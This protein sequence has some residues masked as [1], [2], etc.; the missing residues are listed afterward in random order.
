ME[1]CCIKIITNVSSVLGVISAVV[2]IATWIIPSKFSIELKVIIFLISLIVIFICIAINF[3]CNNCVLKNQL[4]ELR[5]NHK[6]ICKSYDK[7]RKLSEQYKTAFEI[8][9]LSLT[10][11]DGKTKTERN[12]SLCNLIQEIH[13]DFILLEDNSNEEQQ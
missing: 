13:K 4:E 1:R 5:S 6:A 10:I 2:S 9:Y 3:Y 7:V 8:I 12:E 11:S